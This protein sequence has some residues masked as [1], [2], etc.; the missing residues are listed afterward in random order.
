[1]Y[2]LTSLVDETYYRQA[3]Q[4]R[5]IQMRD[6]RGHNWELLRQRAEAE[7]LYFE[8]LAMPDGSATH[9]LVWVAA[10]D[11]ERN[12][13]RRW[14]GRFLNIANPWRD[15][16]L[17]KWTGYRETRYYDAENRQVKSDTPGAR[18]V[19]MLPLA[20]Y[21]LDNPKI[22]TLL[23]DFRDNLNPK[24]RELS[25]RLLE[26]TARNVLQLSASVLGDVPYFLGRTVYDFV[27]GRRGADINQPSR[28]RSYAQLKLLLSLSASLDPQ[29]EDEIARRVEK[30]SSNPL[31]NDSASEQQLARTQYQAL[32]AYAT[33]PDGLAAQL[34]RDRR[35]E[36][37]PLK[38]GKAAQLAFQTLNVL[39]FGNYVHREKATPELVAQ[40]DGTRR[41]GYHERFLREVVKSTPRVEVVWRIED[42]RNSLQFISD[43][44]QYAGKRTSQTV[45]ALFQRTAD[46]AT[47]RLCLA[48]LYR[49]NNET[50]KSELLRIYRA[51]PPYTNWHTLSAQYLRQSVQGAQRITPAD[52]KAITQELGRP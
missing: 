50:A 27:T 8:P 42:V 31:E 28:F 14:D 17:K 34:A 25:R 23:V 13:A 32:I 33:R 20:V 47:Q 30:V 37:V 6:A 24:K 51:S 49:I 36:M 38:H 44:G 5:I 39:T 9:A 10:E 21:G 19:E 18:A 41:F 2:Q 46:E 35:A 16:R 52:V 12:T 4:Q 15:D 48:S 43:N 7:G 40:L 29:L 22:P 3:Q 11:V 45:A 26:D 1:M